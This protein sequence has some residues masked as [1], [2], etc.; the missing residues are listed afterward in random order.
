RPQGCVLRIYVLQAPAVS[1][2][3]RAATHRRDRSGDSA[4]CVDV[5]GQHRHVVTEVRIPLG[6]PPKCVRRPSLPEIRSLRPGR[7]G[8]GRGTAHATGGPL[9]FLVSDLATHN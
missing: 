2:A 1:R 9:P 6:T 4:N 8:T 3:D 5:T 7:R